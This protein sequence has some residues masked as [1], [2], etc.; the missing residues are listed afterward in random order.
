MD[1]W[2][3]GKVGRKSVFCWPPV[4]WGRDGNNEEEQEQEQE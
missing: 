3:D 1:G 2:M 4:E